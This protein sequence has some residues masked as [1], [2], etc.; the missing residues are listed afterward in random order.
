MM[1]LQITTEGKKEYGSKTSN[2][3]DVIEKSYLDALVEAKL[4]Y[5]SRRHG[6]FTLRL[7]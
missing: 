6:M 2:S 1:L 7:F 3:Y 5:H 4:H